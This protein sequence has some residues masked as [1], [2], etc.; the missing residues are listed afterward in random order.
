MDSGSPP[1]LEGLMRKTEIRE[2][3]TSEKRSLPR[4]CLFIDDEAESCDKEEDETEQLEE[5][6]GS[7][8]GF[9]LKGIS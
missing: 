5:D 9:R 6:G 2:L 8:V 3:D 1:S 7:I 4:S